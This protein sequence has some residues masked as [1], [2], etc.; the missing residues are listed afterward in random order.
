MKRKVDEK[1]PT[2]KVRLNKNRRVSILSTELNSTTML[3][4]VFIRN[5]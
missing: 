1:L 4:F 2:K 5:R 3:I